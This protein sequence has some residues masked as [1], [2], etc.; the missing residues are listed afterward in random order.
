MTLQYRPTYV[1]TFEELV[2]IADGKNLTELLKGLESNEPRRVKGWTEA[3]A[4]T[5]VLQ[6]AYIGMSEVI[7]RQI[8]LSDKDG[9]SC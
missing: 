2:K 9:V 3:E 5:F 7:K 8:E 1:V 6:C 4:M